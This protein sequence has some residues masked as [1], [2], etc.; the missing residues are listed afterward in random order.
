MHVRSVYKTGRDLYM[1]YGSDAP[2]RG[3][4]LLMA[5][6]FHKLTKAFPA[7]KSVLCWSER[8]TLLLSS[9]IHALWA[10]A[11]GWR[12]HGLY[13]M[14]CQGACCIPV[15][16]SLAGAFPR[17]ARHRSRRRRRRQGG[18]GRRRR[19]SPR[20]LPLAGGRRSPTVSA[21]RLHRLRLHRLPSRR[22]AGRAACPWRSSTRHP[23]PES[24]RRRR[25]HTARRPHWQ[26]RAA[27][28][29]PDRGSAS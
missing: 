26:T 20:H 7:T 17:E 6:L 25:R 4:H 15:T 24:A 9:V 14:R 11:R 2:G 18:Q 5:L 8:T 23:Q 27:A 1:V 12:A 3:T 22:R 29:A 10:L 28:R 16:P 13:A 21:R 19:P